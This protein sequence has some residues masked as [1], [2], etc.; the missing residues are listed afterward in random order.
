MMHDENKFN[1]TLKSKNWLEHKVYNK[2]PKI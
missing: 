1:L 2:N